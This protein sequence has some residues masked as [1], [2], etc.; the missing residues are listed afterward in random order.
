MISP[1]VKYREVIEY[2]GEFDIQTIKS[3]IKVF[4]YSILKLMKQQSVLVPY[5]LCRIIK[6]ITDRRLKDAVAD[7]ELAEY[8]LM[9]NEVLSFV[10]SVDSVDKD[11]SNSVLYKMLLPLKQ[12][13]D[14]ENESDVVERL[15]ND[16]FSV[17]KYC[18]V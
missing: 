13:K 17:I 9:F 12:F 1:T 3:H 10:V 14:N 4:I 2:E 15:V 16:E 11:K 18:T 8:D 6:I 5:L 7:Q